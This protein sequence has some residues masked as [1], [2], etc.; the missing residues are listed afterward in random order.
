MKF[1]APLAAVLPLLS[2]C[3]ATTGTSPYPER[4][5][6]ERFVCANTMLG[7]FVG[8]PATAALGADIVRASGAKTLQWVASGMMVTM[9]FREDRVRAYLDAANKVSRV[10]C[11]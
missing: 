4:S 3:A 1:L 7:Q 6:A 5:S 10:S 9:D 8:K 11:G 2:A